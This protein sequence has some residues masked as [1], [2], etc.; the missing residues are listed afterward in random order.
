MKK[1]LLLALIGLI[2]QLLCSSPGFAQRDTTKV[3][4]TKIPKD[5]VDTIAPEIEMQTFSSSPPIDPKSML[6]T[7]TPLTPEITALGRFAMQSPDLSSGLPQQNISLCEIKENGINYPL[8][9]FYSFSGF[10]VSEEASNTGLGWGLSEGVIIR[11][12]KH[13]PDEMP[14]M[15]RFEQFGDTMAQQYSAGYLDPQYYVH[16]YYGQKEYNITQNRLFYKLYDAQPDLYIYNFNGYSGKF[17]WLNDEAINLEH[18]DVVIKKVYDIPSNTDEFIIITPDGIRYT[19]KES[20]KA[21]IWGTNAPTCDINPVYTC[22]NSYPTTSWRLAEMKNTVTNMAITFRYNNPSSYGRPMRSSVVT[23]TA[24]EHL[25]LYHI[26]SENLQYVD[27]NLGPTGLTLSEIESDNYKILIVPKSRVDV[28]GSAIDSICFYSKSNL[29]NP[30]KTIKF[31]HAYFG[32]T[33]NANTCWLKL[34][35]L[36]LRGGGNYQK[37]VF[38]YVDETNQDDGLKKDGL[39]IDHWGY[40]N[41]TNNENNLIP[42]TDQ[43]RIT[44]QAYGGGSSISWANREPNFNYCKKFAL[45]KI[46]YPTGGHTQY[47]YESAAS[48]GLRVAS[49]V[50]FDGE[51]STNKYYQYP[52]NTN[53]ASYESDE[54]VST[55][56]CGETYDLNMMVFSFYANQKNSLDFFEETTNFYG[57]VVEKIGTSDGQGGKSEYHFERLGN[58]WSFKTFLT[59]KIDYEYNNPNFIA[60]EKYFYNPINLKTVPYWLIPRMLNTSHK[61]GLCPNDALDRSITCAPTDP[62]ND[63]HYILGDFDYGTQSVNANWYRLDSISTTKDQVVVTKKYTHKPVDSQTGLPKHCSPIRIEERLSNGNLKKTELFYPGETDPDNPSNTLGIPQMWDPVYSKNF[64]SP[65]IKTRNYVNSI[66]ISKDASA[67]AYDSS[68]DLIVRTAYELF[69]DGTASSRSAWTFTYDNKARVTSITKENDIPTAVLWDVTG[70]YVMARVENATYSQISSQSGKACTYSSLTL[71]N[72]LKSIVPSSLITTY[73]YNPLY[74]MT[75][76]T[77]PTGVSTHYTYDVFGRL[78]SVK[79]DDQKLLK[80]YSYHYKNQ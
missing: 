7:L 30:V 42:Y 74:G 20:D 34:K 58:N 31:N 3:N 16:P 13:V 76:Q 64:I 62:L 80:K 78:E 9:L 49:M 44:L 15:K 45:D 51:K 65:V 52:A 27:S 10:R 43:I 60:K 2:S 59:E 5:S 47:N 63:Y 57:T 61:M 67:Y 8:N 6:K 40:Y 17:L 48:K 23:Y 56:C 73:S 37:Y 25:G 69:Q 72:S 24:S 41:G 79:D 32:K 75:S 26:D 39:G 1:Y 28:E 19:F 55:T 36:I 54:Y 38:S 14:I 66:L 53:Y 29:T 46:Q 12:V 33:T 77:D 71:Y 4:P 70:S 18:N 68:N 22:N 35:E 11:I 50:D 21:N